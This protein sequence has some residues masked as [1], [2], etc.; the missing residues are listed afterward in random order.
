MDQAETLGFISAKWR[1][2]CE[3]ALLYHNLAINVVVAR[4]ETS[5][6]LNFQLI[7]KV[8]SITA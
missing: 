1:G 3:F 8:K 6:V 5:W 2:S 4:G 7:V